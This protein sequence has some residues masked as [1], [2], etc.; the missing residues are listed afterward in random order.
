MKGGIRAPRTLGG[1]WAY[2]ID[3]GP[4]PGGGRNQRQVAGFRSRGEA[5]TALAEALAGQ[6]GGDRRT[7]AGFL[8]LVWLPAK[9]A[10]VDRSTFDQYVWA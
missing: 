3:L 10:E 2:R 6:G 1:T 7:V 9:Q 4:A 5:E 8:E